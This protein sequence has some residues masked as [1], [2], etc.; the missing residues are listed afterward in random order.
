MVVMIVMRGGHASQ[1]REARSTL[2]VHRPENDVDQSLCLGCLEFV[3][4][5]AWWPCPQ[6]R[7]ARAVLTDEPPERS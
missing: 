4:H 2:L 6:A 1:V 5:F 3:C 7:W